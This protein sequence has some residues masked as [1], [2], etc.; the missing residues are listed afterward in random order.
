MFKDYKTIKLKIK[1]QTAWLILSRPEKLNSINSSM[2][3]ELSETIDKIEENRNIRC[4]IVMGEGKKAFSAGAD[5]TEIGKLTPEIATAFSMNGQK[6]FSKLERLSKPVIA[7]ISGYALGGGFEL[8]LACDFRIATKN[9]QFGCPEIQFGFI[10]GWGATQRLPMIAGIAIAKR[11][12]L[13]GDRIEANEALK[14]G[15]VDRVV[16]SEKL[17][18]EAELL[19]KRLC[20]YSP[21]ALKYAKHA[22]YSENENS[23]KSGFEM[24][25]EFF[26]LLFSK[27]VATKKEQDF[28]FLSNENMD[29]T[30]SN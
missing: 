10:P 13:L 28:R 2:L 5:L 9:S 4:L 26:S 3:Q 17:R 6:V 7:A 8:A 12:I 1:Q 22:I 16:S 30:K 29:N 24:E 15:L 21:K 18:T 19:A 25:R 23:F 14:V 20:D 27:K 11:L